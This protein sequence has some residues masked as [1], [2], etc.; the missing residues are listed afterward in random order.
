MIGVGMSMLRQRRTADA[1][2]GRLTRDSA[3]TLLPR[4]V[5]IGFGVGLATGFFGIGGGFLIVPGLI[6]AT[7]MPLLFA[8]STSLVVV[9]ELGL[10]TTTSYALSS[11]VD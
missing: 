7:P 5:P 4:L 2:H 8:I 1:S 6:L 9:S 10:T 11:P 3:S